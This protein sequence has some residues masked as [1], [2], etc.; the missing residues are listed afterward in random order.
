LVKVAAYY[1]S[2]D[3]AQPGPGPAAVYVDPV[4]AGKSAAAACAGCHGDAG[5]SKLGGIPSL[6]GQDPQYL[7]TAMKAYRSGQRKNDTMKSMLAAASDADINHIALFYA[8]QP[9]K[10]SQNPAAG[11][12]RATRRPAKPIRSAAPAAT[13]T[14]ASAAVPRRRALPARMPNI[15]SPRCGPI[16]AAAATTRP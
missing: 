16:R 5:V 4:A 1:A 12:A 7:K 6:I 15:L 10:R 13:A 2:L 11:D 8:L 3:P 9:A 14:R